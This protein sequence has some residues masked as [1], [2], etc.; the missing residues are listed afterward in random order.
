MNHI[1]KESL[2]PSSPH[3]SP[4]SHIPRPVRHYYGDTVRKLFLVGA[5]VMLAYLP[6]E[7]NL[8]PGIMNLIVL[9]ALAVTFLAGFTNPRQRVVIAFDTAIAALACILFEYFAITLYTTEHNIFDLVFLARQGLAIDFLI[10]FYFSSKT[11]RA[12]TIRS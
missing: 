11:I 6:R 10:A 4:P 3:S 2:S 1:D 9:G 12:M 5:I 7:R 8:L